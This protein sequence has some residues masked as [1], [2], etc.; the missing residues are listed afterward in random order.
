[1]VLIVN[2]VEVQKRDAEMS[3]MAS[4][5]GG[6]RSGDNVSEIKGGGWIMAYT[7]TMKE[8]V[9]RRFNDLMCFGEGYEI[10]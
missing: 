7:G 5:E 6:A 2:S 10:G 3:Q 1:M 8:V 4:C 9:L